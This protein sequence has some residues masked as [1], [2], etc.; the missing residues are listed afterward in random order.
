MFTLHPATAPTPSSQRTVWLPLPVTP[1]PSLR[2]ATRIQSTEGIV[3]IELG[4]PSEGFE[5]GDLLGD[6]IAVQDWMNELARL[7]GK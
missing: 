3:H 1:S 2:Y 4:Q 6:I 5:E 7:G